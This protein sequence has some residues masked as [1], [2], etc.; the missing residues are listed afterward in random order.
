MGNVPNNTPFKVFVGRQFGAGDRV[1][2][3]R[4]TV[5]PLFLLTR[6]PGQVKRATVIVQLPPSGV[7]IISAVID[8]VVPEP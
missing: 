3:P 5:D 1:I 7:G 2:F 4:P 8:S 6:L